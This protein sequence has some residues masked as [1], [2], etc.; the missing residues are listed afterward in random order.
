MLRYLR[1]ALGGA[2]MGPPV[3]P[4]WTDRSEGSDSPEMNCLNEAPVEALRGVI[5]GIVYRDSQGKVTQR[6]VQVQQIS[7]GYLIGHCLM[8]L[9]RR[10]FRVDRIQEMIDL[11][12]GE[13][14]LDPPQFLAALAH[15]ADKAH[16]ER[17]QNATSFIEH[18]A[19][20]LRVLIVIAGGDGRLGK[21]ERA[22]LK[23]YAEERAK[24]LKASFGK[25]ELDAINRW[26]T[27]QYPTEEDLEKSIRAL[28]KGGPSAV[29]SII[30]MAEIVAGID[31]K[32]TKGEKKAFGLLAAALRSEFAEAR[33]AA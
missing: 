14:H 8:M 22:I 33:L 24:D 13:L 18:I 31:G 12:T 11:E 19:D 4:T 10:T 20:E 3:N 25:T 21:P 29:D 30:E 1:N 15:L 17:Q 7:G 27:A 6:R 28:A 32:V 5:V 9:D 26:L 16:R 2:R 23:R